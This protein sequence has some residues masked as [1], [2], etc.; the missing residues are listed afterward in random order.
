MARSVAIVAVHQI[1]FHEA[2]GTLSLEELVFE[3][4]R[5]TLDA[6]GLTRKVIQQVVVASSDQ[7]DGRAISVMLMAG[8]AG[9]YFKDVL[10]LSSA[11]EHAFVTAWLRI[12]SG[13]FDNALVLSWSKCSEAPMPLI[14]HLSTDPF[15]ARQLAVERTAMA[16][17]QVCR[18][19]S[20][21][22][23]TDAD[24][25]AAV[26][27][28]LARAR[29]NPRAHVRGSVSPDDVR[30]SPIV[31]WPLRA[32]HLPPWSDGA[33]GLVL[34]A[35]EAAK[36]LD[37][38][39]AWIRGM[40]WASD[41]YWLSDR[42]DEGLPSLRAAAHRA[43]AMAG[44]G[45]SMDVAELHA[46]TAFHEPV[47]FA[48]LAAAGLV[49][50]G[51]TAISPS[52]GSFGANPDFATGLVRIAEAAMQ[53]MGTAGPHQIPGVHTALAHSTNGFGAQNHTVAVLADTPAETKV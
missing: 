25:V 22:R 41:G 8:P 6:A 36:G 10:N 30:C 29:Q 23:V 48:E 42:L 44:P 13:A 38:R 35:A 50:S 46:P 16:A 17:L 5:G 43:H 21:G 52:G 4:A 19:Q 31:A 24:A 51:Q 7:T 40:G 37:R 28:N 1:G 47:I 15:F 2:M 12:A 33:C 49:E 32:L 20:A 3:T 9:G 11:G 14:D 26:C 39:L 27:E 34:M 18:W 45:V 53:V